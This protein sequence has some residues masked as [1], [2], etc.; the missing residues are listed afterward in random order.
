MEPARDRWS[1]LESVTEVEGHST[2][3][4]NYPRHPRLTWQGIRFHANFQTEIPRQA[5]ELTHCPQAQGD[6]A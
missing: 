1:D 5:L 3:P 2:Q 4:A 6:E